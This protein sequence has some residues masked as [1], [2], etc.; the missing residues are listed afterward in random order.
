MIK[1]GLIG[2]GSIAN[3]H[4]A[5]AERLSEKAVFT[6]FADIAENMAAKVE[7]AE[8]FAD[9][10]DMFDKVDAVILA[11]PH[12]LHFEMGMTCLEAGKH[13]LL[14][15]PLA[16]TKAECEELV[17]AD[18]SPDPVL[19]VG[20]IMRHDPL[21][22]EMGRLIKEEVYGKAFQ[23]S[24]WTEQYTD[25]S[26]GAWM[27]QADKLG[28]GQLFSHGCH[29]VDLMLDWMGKPESGTHIGTNLGTPWMEREGTSNMSIKFAD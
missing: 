14:E 7:G 11:V 5:T 6:A 21:W 1:L 10:R 26:R 8:A 27:G 13:L 24:I 20:Y 12:D 18:K 19:M 16:L 2:C 28:G 22:T 23:V 4:I 15:K 3:T 29:Y 9:Y 17:A 25:T